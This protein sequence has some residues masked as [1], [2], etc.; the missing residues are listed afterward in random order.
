MV[1]T[2]VSTARTD[3]GS[4]APGGYAPARLLR[5]SSFVLLWL[6]YGISAF[7]D[8]LSELGMMRELRVEQS[9]RQVQTQ[10]LMTFLFFAPFFVCSA[11]AGTIADRLPRRLVMIS[12]DVVRAVIVFFLPV[13]VVWQVH[14][15][16]E[17]LQWGDVVRALLPLL[18][19]GV[20]S[21]LF[22]PARQALLPQLVRE[23][24]LVQANSVTSGLGT[25]AAMLSNMIGGILADI[26][27][28]LNFMADAATFV[29]SAA[30]VTGI[31]VP[32]RTA[33]TA[34]TESF[35]RSV[36]RGIRYVAAHRR[37][38]ELILLASLFWTAAG[39]FTSVLP[40]V[41][42]DRYGL[43]Y[44][45]VGAMRGTLA[46]GMLLGAGLLT[47][48]GD[49]IHNELVNL[50]AIVGAGVWLVGFA[51]SRS[52]FVGLP[53][54]LLVGV[55][56]AM[57]LISVSTT[58][59]RI[60]P[61]RWRGR[62]FG[63]SD[64]TTIAGLLAATGLLGL[65][66]IPHLDALVP[67]I[68]T[69]LGVVMVAIGVVM[70][71]ARS[72]GT[73]LRPWQLLLWRVNQFYARWWFRAQRDGPCTVPPTGPAILAANHTSFIDP[74]LLYATGRPR[75]ICFLVAREYYDRPVTGRLLRSIC[76]IATTRSGHDLP[77]TRE[78]FRRLDEGR[79]IGIFPQG[80]IA[81]PGEHV[82]PHGGIALLALRSRAPVIPVHISGT[83]HS[84]SIL[85]TFLRRHRARI[86]YGKPVDLSAFYGRPVD[87]ALRDQ[88]G[89]IIL[90]RILALAPPATGTREAAGG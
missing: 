57:L 35:F 88:V 18:V 9:G 1:S 26:S 11:V 38:G 14:S 84:E 79:L 52:V 75:L 82:E 7:G 34:L 58:L 17:A 25:I 90:E 29:A 20:F 33:Q 6:A 31:R 12:A 86:R 5:N 47:F 28:R 69:A 87:K 27:P 42:F 48:L 80:R 2:R 53:L 22:S 30:L 41:V 16:G 85:W 83:R 37:T 89:R 23:D 8:H 62:V 39:I 56:G 61:N 66:P 43:G 4:P 50:V 54:G 51:W 70:H 49:R 60:V 76:C 67:K 63:I 71:A 45:W 40:S 64:M 3:A 24:E 19:L 74:V 32:K 36:A 21:S 68:L 73:G 44:A 77:A 65:W 59:Q 72:R 81:L 78:A 10:A 46:A 15:R 13:W 55:S